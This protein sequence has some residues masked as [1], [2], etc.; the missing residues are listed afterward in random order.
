MLYNVDECPKCRA[1]EPVKEPMVETLHVEDPLA[2]QVG[3]S[4]YKNL[5]IQPVE[6]NHANELPFIEGSVVKYVTRHREKGGAKDIRKAIHFLELL[7]KLEYPEDK[8]P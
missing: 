7:L 5:K 1:E 3:G 2:K 6:Y 4:H 8:A